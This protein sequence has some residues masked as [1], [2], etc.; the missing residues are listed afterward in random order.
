MNKLV[1]LK[2]D[3]FSPNIIFG[4]CEIY[5]DSDGYTNSLRD[6]SNTI[7][8]P[9]KTDLQN[10]ISIWVDLNATKLKIDSTAV[11]YVCGLIP[12][13]GITITSYP[14]PTPTPT[15]TP[16]QTKTPTP[17]PTSTIGASP[18]PTNTQTP[19][20]TLTP[21][22]TSTPAVFTFSGLVTYVNGTSSS[23]PGTGTTWTSL[24]TG[25]TYN[26]TLFNSP[27]WTAGTNGFFTF[28]GVNDYCN[29]NYANPTTGDYTIGGWVKATTSGTQKIF[30]Q[31]GL[32]TFGS[33]WSFKLGKYLDNKFRFSVVLTSAGGT[34]LNVDSTTTLVD[35]T[36]YY[37]IGKWTAGTNL[38]IYINGSLEGTNT[39]ALTSLRTSTV[40][41][42]LARTD[43]P[44]YTNCS[45]G[46]FE[47]YDSA[48]SDAQ[49][50]SNFNA[51]KSI[52][53]Y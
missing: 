2:I 16:T 26:G 25:T 39:T 51:R 4:G 50:L 32:D 35:N 48:L 38:K 3:Y 9:S 47:I 23:Y 40:N 20:K 53:G 11:T 36:W 15:V 14:V 13:S 7:Y 49:I 1:D 19:T 41:W 44:S 46:E 42:L 5:Q 31:R 43:G 27:T 33:G 52:Y 24:A 18:T 34:Q 6:P 21:T 28:D 8:T 45:I 10:G 17:T 30:F 29:I 37:I 22:P 12:S